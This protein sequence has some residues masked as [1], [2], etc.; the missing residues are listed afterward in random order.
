MWRYVFF[1]YTANR[2]FTIEMSLLSE[3]DVNWEM[4]CKTDTKAY[5]W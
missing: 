5:F 3:R 2:Y 4:M 1:K